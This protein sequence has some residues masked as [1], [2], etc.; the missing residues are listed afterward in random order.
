MHIVDVEIFTPFYQNKTSITITFFI[1]VYMLSSV[2]ALTLQNNRYIFSP[3][4][5]TCKAMNEVFDQPLGNTPFRFSS[6]LCGKSVGI[7]KTA[8]RTSSRDW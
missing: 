3:M 7:S 5:F 4:Q 1:V 8:V 6:K 2:L